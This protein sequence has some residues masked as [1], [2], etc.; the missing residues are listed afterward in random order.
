MFAALSNLH[1]AMAGAIAIDD[2][3]LPLPLK[4]ATIKNDFATL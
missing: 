4:L 2:R 1:T 3:R